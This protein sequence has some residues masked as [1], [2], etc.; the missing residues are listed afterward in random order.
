MDVTTTTPRTGAPALAAPASQPVSNR[1]TSDYETFLRMLTVQLENQDP[2]NPVENSEFA[3]QL[4]TFSGVE[5]QTRTNQLLEDLA[6]QMNGSNFSQLANWVGMEARVDAPLFFDGSPVELATSIPRNAETAFVVAR[7]AAGQVVSRD[8]VPTSGTE[9]IWAGVG[10]N[11]TPLPNGLYSFT[12]ESFTGDELLQISD[13]PV[14]AEVQEA[15]ILNGQTILVF[16]GG[17]TA[18]ASAVTAL[19]NP[20]S[21]L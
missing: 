18:P 8:R 3:V 5:Q 17:T 15:Q 6:Q 13:I 20:G 9:A 4:A 19:R 14:Y 16:P 21:G 10:Q 11:G 1:V 7:D 12:V 2:L